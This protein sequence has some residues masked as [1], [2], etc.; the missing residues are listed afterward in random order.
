MDAESSHA[1][2][3]SDEPRVAGGDPWNRRRTNISADRDVGAI[4]AGGEAEVG[5]KAMESRKR[6]SAGVM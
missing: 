5:L 6:G 2:A 4:I 1:V 3:R